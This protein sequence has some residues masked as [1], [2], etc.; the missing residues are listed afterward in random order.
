MMGVETVRNQSCSI[1]V[2]LIQ[3]RNRRGSNC[4][5]DS[6]LNDFW[7]YH[8]L[9][10]GKRKGGGGAINKNRR[11]SEFAQESDLDDFWCYVLRSATDGGHGRLCC[12]LGQ[13]KVGNF[14]LM[15]VVGRGQQ[16]VFQLEISVHNTSAPDTD[17]T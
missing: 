17:E 11:G 3:H 8:C 9:K 16:Q 15:D 7:R 5:Q 2:E 12:L 14:D 1:N 6:D 13:P 10:G 4:V